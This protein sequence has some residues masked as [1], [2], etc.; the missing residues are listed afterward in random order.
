MQK[1]LLVINTIFIMAVG[2]FVLPLFL[3]VRDVSMQVQDL[4]QRNEQ[5]LEQAA[6]QADQFQKSMQQAQQELILKVDQFE[7]T[8]TAQD[9][10]IAAVQKQLD[11]LVTELKLINQGNTD[12]VTKAN[13]LE[14]QVAEIASM[15]GTMYDKILGEVLKSVDKNLS[16]SNS[17]PATQRVVM[18]IA[19]SES[20]EG[21]WLLVL[22][23]GFQRQVAWKQV[24]PVDYQFSS[25]G[26]SF[27]GTYQKRGDQ[28]VLVS[29]SQSRL[30][31][32]FIWQI[33]NAH[34]MRLIKSPPTSMIG[35]DY[36]GAT[37]V[38]RGASTN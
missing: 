3:D 35:S 16:T 24:S 12:V 15:Q 2:A 4:S 30:N 25:P 29:A 34:A 1:T 26:S 20:I 37:L 13:N 18:P 22:P 33:D 31:G 5:T 8:K 32:H 10:K 14:K 11:E 28:L 17:R 19:K 38:R 6:T 36:T 7:T 9:E 27:T 21:S 23:A